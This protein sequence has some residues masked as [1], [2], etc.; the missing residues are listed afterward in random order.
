MRRGSEPLDIA[1][2]ALELERALGIPHSRRRHPERVREL[3]ARAWRREALSEGQ[4]AALLRLDRVA[5][6]AILDGEASLRVAGA[7]PQRGAV[8]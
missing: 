1:A 4:L 8:P 6:R 3:A 5:L 2:A 7:L